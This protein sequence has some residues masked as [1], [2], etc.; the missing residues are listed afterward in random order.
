MK[1]RTEDRLFKGVLFRRYPRSKWFSARRYFRATSKSGVAEAYLHRA[2]WSFHNGRIPAGHDIHHVDGDHSNNALSNLLCV[3]KSEHRRLDTARGAYRSKAAMRHLTKIRKLALQWHGSEEGRLWHRRH[4]K[5]Q[6]K[7]RA[8]VSLKCVVCGDAFD[9]Y[10]SDGMYC[11]P[12]CAT[13]ARRDSGVDDVNY[14]CSRCGV[15]FRANK[16]RK[17]K[18]CRLSC[19]GVNNERPSRRA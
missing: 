9:G 6:W 7:N 5:E 10:F 4:A 19:D 16:H 18:I 1:P 15:I 12:S 8:L 11:S 2:I 14:K 17:R 3:T 13:Q